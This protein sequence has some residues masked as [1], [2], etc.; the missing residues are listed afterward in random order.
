[1]APLKGEVL[2]WETDSNRQTHCDLKCM[3]HQYPGEGYGQIPWT[4]EDSVCLTAQT[5]LRKV[6]ENVCYEKSMQRFHIFLAPK[7]ISFNSIFHEPFKVLSYTLSQ[8]HLSLWL[9]LEH[10]AADWLAQ[11]YLS[12][13]PPLGTNNKRERP[14]PESILRFCVNV[15]LPTFL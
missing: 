13:V 10:R 11:Y 15:F 8:G 7:Q 4:Y 12:V 2:E 9:S 1:M 3:P 5:V 14:W 6:V